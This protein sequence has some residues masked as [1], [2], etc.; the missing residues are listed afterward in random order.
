MRIFF[1]PIEYLADDL[2]VDAHRTYHAIE[3]CYINKTEKLK[4]FKEY[5]C[6]I[7]LRRNWFIN[8]HR[9]LVSE[10][11]FRFKKPG[12]DYIHNSLASLP[13]ETNRPI[14]SVPKEYSDYDIKYLIHRYR[15]SN[16]V[17]KYTRR[18]IPSF[19]VGVPRDLIFSCETCDKNNTCNTSFKKDYNKCA[20]WVQGEEN[21]NKYPSPIYLQ[22]IKN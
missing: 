11:E 13:F 20:N 7:P 22:N 12:Q 21:R 1:C 9:L 14:W 6:D 3:S 2:L 10:L 8:Y 4:P 19:L 15:F 16:V 5:F 17:H 18:N